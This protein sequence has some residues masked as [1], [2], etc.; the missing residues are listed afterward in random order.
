MSVT[1][2]CKQVTQ[3]FCHG[4]LLIFQH[5]EKL[6]CKVH[7][8][9][10]LQAYIYLYHLIPSC[11]LHKLESKDLLSTYRFFSKPGGNTRFC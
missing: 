3:H 11:K 2:Y 10:S 1:K 8:N 9:K 6:Y 5:N 7:C 4:Q